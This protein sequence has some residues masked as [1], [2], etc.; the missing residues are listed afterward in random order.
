MFVECLCGR[1]ENKPH[2]PA[3]RE[4]LAASLQE[5]MQQ[6]TSRCQLK[7]HL[8]EELCPQGIPFPGHPVWWLSEAGIGRARHLGPLWNDWHKQYSLQGSRVGRASAGPLP[9]PASSPFCSQELMPNKALAPQT[10]CRHLLL[11]IQPA[12]A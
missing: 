1:H 7:V 11:K 6:A 3:S 9:R 5:C 12:M 8:W 2:T 10:P 4:G